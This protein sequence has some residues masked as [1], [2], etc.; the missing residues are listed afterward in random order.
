MAFENMGYSRPSANLQLGPGAPGLESGK[1]VKWL[2]CADCDLG[3]LG[4]S[5]EGG[6]E[7]WLSVQRVRYG[8]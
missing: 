2:S 1:K 7:S 4:W 8:V 6:D 5:Y 3:P